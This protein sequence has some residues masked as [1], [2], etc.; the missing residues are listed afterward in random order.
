MV[1]SQKK[2]VKTVKTMSLCN[3]RESTSILNEC[4]I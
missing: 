4:P 1:Q 3:E 2:I